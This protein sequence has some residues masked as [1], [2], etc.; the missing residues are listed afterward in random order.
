MHDTAERLTKCF[1]A[2]FPDV[3]PGQIATAKPA[4]VGD[5]DSVA[6]VTLVSVLEEEFRIEI[7]SDDIEYL[8]SFGDALTYLNRRLGAGAKS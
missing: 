7:D 2:V 4:T 8:L 6:T 5:W 1:I 3:D